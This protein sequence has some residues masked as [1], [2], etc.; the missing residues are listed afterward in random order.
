MKLLDPEHF[1][2]L[3]F[4]EVFS[5]AAFE[6]LRNA[7]LLPTEDI[8]DID[9]AIDEWRENF[10]ESNDEKLIQKKL[11]FDN[12]VKWELYDACT[13]ALDGFFSATT[14]IK[15]KIKILFTYLHHIET[16]TFYWVFPNEILKMGT[17][18]KSCNDFKTIVELV[19]L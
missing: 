17:L 19:S 12:I 13:I 14:G 9:E 2:K 1:S 10:I 3:F 6:G 15:L 18:P 16:K 11:S 7:L 5:N 4:D 8:N